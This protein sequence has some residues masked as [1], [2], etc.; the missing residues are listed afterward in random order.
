MIKAICFDL[1]GTL[2]PLNQEIFTKAYF[3]ALTA[4]MQPYGYEPEKLIQTIWKGTGA[5][6]RNDGRK[7]NETVFWNI[8][9][10]VYGN[11]YDCEIFN[12]FYKQKFDTAKAVCGFNPQANEAIQ[13]L[14]QA[15]YALVLASN[16]I[17]P[18]VAQQH[19]MQWAGVDPSDFTYITSYENSFYCKPNPAYYQALTQTIGCRP[20]DCLMVGNDVTEDMV[21]QTTGMKVFLMTECLINPKNTDISVYPHGG[22]RELLDFVKAQ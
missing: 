3:H 21:A 16:P 9:R 7:T 17:F 20:Q 14:K 1:D 15:G 13:T 18:M 11:D 6:V 19:R 22:F 5:M 12:R 8:F 10:E 2:L 4:A